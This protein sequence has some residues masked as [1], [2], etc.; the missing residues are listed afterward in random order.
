MKSTEERES[1]G[2][3]NPRPGYR[4][5]ATFLGLPGADALTKNE[6]THLFSQ[7]FPLE[8]LERIVQAIA[9]ND[10]DFPNMIVDPLDRASRQAAGR[11]STRESNLVYR[12][13]SVWIMALRGF[14]QPEIARS[15]LLSA[16]TIAFD[17]RT[18]LQT[19]LEDKYGADY[20]MMRLSVYTPTMEPTLYWLD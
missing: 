6:M 13:A 9:P 3:G 2:P 4:E 16:N 12:L 14:R 10:P 8:A 7:G 15:F 20:V 5:V 1:L 17:G 19:I 11:L 18:P